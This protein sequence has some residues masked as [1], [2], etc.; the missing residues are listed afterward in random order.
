MEKNESIKITNIKE[1]S[2]KDFEDM[3]LE[4]KDLTYP[5]MVQL[6]CVSDIPDAMIAEKCKVKKEK[7]VYLRKNKY[8]LTLYNI[9]EHIRNVYGINPTIREEA[10]AIVAY[11][12]R[13]GYIEDLHAGKHS[14]I[15]ED[16]SYSRI[17]NEEMRKLMIECCQKMAQLLE[18][19]EK[20][21]NKYYL[22]ISQY[23]NMFC[24]NWI[25]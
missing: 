21:P 22:F 9:S 13:N 11:A 5:M 14:D 6:W 16:N 8:K 2:Y 20:D 3:N 25:K 19:K 10:N 12:F 23:H 4:F 17:T 24:S 15:L 7:I 1:I 18:M